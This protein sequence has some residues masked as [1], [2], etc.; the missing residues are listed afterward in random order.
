MASLHG[1]GFSKRATIVPIAVLAALLQ[2]LLL[3]V[4]TGGGHARQFH[5]ATSATSANSSLGASAGALGSAD[6]GAPAHGEGAPAPAC[7]LHPHC[8]VPGSLALAFLDRAEASVA[9]PLATGRTTPLGRPAE[10]G[11]QGPEPA[12]PWSSRAPPSLG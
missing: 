2:A 4:A 3:F 7:P 9:L 6:C 5:S 10:P 11:A 1:R 8:C 12:P